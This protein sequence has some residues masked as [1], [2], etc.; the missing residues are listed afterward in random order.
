MGVGVITTM[1]LELLDPGLCIRPD[2]RTVI[3]IS[4]WLGLPDA[5]GQCRKAVFSLLGEGASDTQRLEA[6]G[7]AQLPTMAST[8]L[9]SAE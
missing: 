9:S 1:S 7:A 2:L 5:T 6:R 3:L 8:F 4:G